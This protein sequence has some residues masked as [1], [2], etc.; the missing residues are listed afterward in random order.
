MIGGSFR[1]VGISSSVGSCM[2]CCG[3]CYLRCHHC[4]GMSS[5]YVV[6]VNNLFSVNQ[7]TLADFYGITVE[8]FF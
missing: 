7:A 1:Q 2:L 8:Y 5:N 6:I 3:L 4:V